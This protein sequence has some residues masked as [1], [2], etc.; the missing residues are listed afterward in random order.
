MWQPPRFDKHQAGRRIRAVSARYTPEGWETTG[1]SFADYDKMHVARR[2]KQQERRLDTPSWA[3]N[4]KELREVLLKFCERRFYLRPD[5]TIV[6]DEQRIARIRKKEL[7]IADMEAPKLAGLRERYKTEPEEKR[8]RLESDIQTFDSTLVMYRR[9]TL[10]VVAAI[11]YYY[12]RMGYDSV[13]VAESVG[14]KPPAVRQILAKLRLTATGSYY[15][16]PKEQRVSKAR[17]EMARV[18]DLF[19][20]VQYIVDAVERRA[21]EKELRAIIAGIPV[22][23]RERRPRWTLDRLRFIYMLRLQGKSWHH[24]APKVGI[25]RAYSLQQGFNYWMERLHKLPDFKKAA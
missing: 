24:I 14:L 20:K 15:H 12:L 23:K 1:I 18:R 25:R 4:D 3:V 22:P 9:G 17:A 5:P 16:C 8:L 6:T 7:A 13:Q 11:V 2:A 19:K 10:P 21:T